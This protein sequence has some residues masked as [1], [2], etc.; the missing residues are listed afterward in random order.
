MDS[1]YQQIN[2]LCALCFL[3]GCLSGWSALHQE[4][5]KL[6]MKAQEICPHKNT[7]TYVDSVTPCCETTKIT[8][9]DCDKVI[10]RKTDCR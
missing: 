1:L 8:C 9:L 6:R 10:S 7:H 5:K 2:I 3:A 4:V